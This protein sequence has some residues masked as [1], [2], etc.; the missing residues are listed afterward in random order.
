M[1][2]ATHPNERRLLSDM[3]RSSPP[4]R[5]SFS[6][7]FQP[8]DESMDSELVG[9]S[10]LSLN[11]LLTVNLDAL[12]V[13]LKSKNHPF[14][15][16]S[17]EGVAKELLVFSVVSPVQQG[18]VVGYMKVSVEALPVLLEIQREDR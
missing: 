15:S 2:E 12:A 13:E 3:L 8:D 6:V 14:C 18:V 7:F 5:I 16:S 9:V 11:R 1:D 4:G 17:M 10:A